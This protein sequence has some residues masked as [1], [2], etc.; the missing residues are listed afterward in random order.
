MADWDNIDDYLARIP[1]KLIKPRSTDNNGQ[2][3]KPGNGDFH[4]G[5]WPNNINASNTNAEMASEKYILPMTISVVIA[6][7][8]PHT[9]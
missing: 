8:S 4:I 1:K 5:A 6:A 2:V 9:H 7:S 3:Y